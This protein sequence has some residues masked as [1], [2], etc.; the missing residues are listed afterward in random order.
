MKRTREHLQI[1]G[2]GPIG[3]TWEKRVLLEAWRQTLTNDAEKLEEVRKKIVNAGGNL[4]LLYDILYDKIDPRLVG[5]N[6]LR[7]FAAITGLCSDIVFEF[8][9]SHYG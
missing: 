2:D 5:G 1:S 7:T 6:K 3:G 9:D 8:D 4:E